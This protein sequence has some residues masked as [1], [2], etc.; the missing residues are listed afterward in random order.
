MMLSSPQLLHKLLEKL[1]DALAAYVCYQIFNGAQVVQLFDSWAHHLTPQ[2]YMEF[3]LKYSNIVMDKVHKQYPNTPLIYH[4]NGGS[5]KLE[6]IKNYCTSDVIGLDQWTCMHDCR[7]LF[8]DERVLQGNIDPVILF[9]PQSRIVE[10][11]QQCSKD[12][13]GKHHIINVGHGVIQQT[14]EENVA[15]FCKTVRGVQS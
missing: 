6:I 1:S 9:G 11:V 7:S 14:P 15:V 2:Q 12:G 13:G 8:G 4:A 10:E 3:S 5:G